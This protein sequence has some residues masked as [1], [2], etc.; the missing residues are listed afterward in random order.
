MQGHATCGAF[1]IMR[2]L[3]AFM[4]FVAVLLSLL[5]AFDAIILLNASDIFRFSVFSVFAIGFGF[6]GQR[7]MRSG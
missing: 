5:F 6:F 1:R 2:L 3:R 4:G 7:W